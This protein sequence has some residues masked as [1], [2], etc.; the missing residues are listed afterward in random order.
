[1]N[2]LKRILLIILG[3]ALIGSLSVW[4]WAKFIVWVVSEYMQ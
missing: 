1:M 2:E 3:G 4:M